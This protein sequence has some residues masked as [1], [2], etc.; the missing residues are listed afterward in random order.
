M[1]LGLGTDL[2]EVGRVE[3][4]YRRHGDRFLDR[5][6]TPTERADCLGRAR[7]AI[8]LAGRVAA[9]EA[10]MKALGTG[11]A[12]GVH[13]TDIEVQA[14]AGG[15]PALTFGGGARRH[16]ESRGIRQ[17]WLSLSHDGDYATAVVIVTD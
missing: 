7:P 15:A 8:H 11:W 9:K 10:A 16:A 5:V 13:W 6:F 1:I 2:V 17:S 14:T 4:I 12:G 3:D